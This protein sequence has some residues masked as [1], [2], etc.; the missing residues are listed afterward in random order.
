MTCSLC[1]HR[2]LFIRTAHEEST[3]VVLDLV[4]EYDTFYM[5]MHLYLLLAVHYL[6]II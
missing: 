3:S 1:Y 6:H 2:W 5:Q 4:R